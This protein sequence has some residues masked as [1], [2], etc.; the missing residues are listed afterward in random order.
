MNEQIEQFKQSISGLNRCIF[1]TQIE[2]RLEIVGTC[3]KFTGSKNEKGYG[4]VRI[5][6]RKGKTQSLHRWTWQTMNGQMP[7]D[8]MADHLCR[9]RDCCNPFHI[10]A[11]TAK[12]N[13]LRGFGQGALNASKT[14]CPHGHAYTTENTRITYGR[15]RCRICLRIAKKTYRQKQK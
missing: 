15:R 12:V 4:T 7:K 9:N 10:E 6:G 2:P 3:W 14:H 1:T 5:G 8:L 13:S 11:V